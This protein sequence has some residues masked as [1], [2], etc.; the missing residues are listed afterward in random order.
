[1][2][3]VEVDTAAMSERD[4]TRWLLT[5]GVIGPVLFVV[6]FLI[7]G[8][9][10]PGYDP[11]RHFVSTL[12]LGDQ[13]WQQIANFVI[14]GI[15]IIAGAAGLRRTMRDG[16]G[17]RWGPILIGAAGLGVLLAGV[18][19]T[20]PAMGYP[21]G[22]PPGLPTTSSWHGTIHDMV[23]LVVF[24]GL[25]I[26]A[27]VMARR[28]RGERGRWALYSVLTG[29]GMLVGFVLIFVFQDWL[30]LTQ[31]IS[32]V[33]GFGWVAQLCLRF[34]RELSTGRA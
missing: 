34:R 11:M 5:G 18:F 28:F 21:P 3:R 17:S 26:A 23:S 7:E 25:P 16:P 4:K 13:G 8:W 12:S 29:I 27:F 2:R 32:I 15:L 9:T 20:D 22:S 6:V 31:R 19:V 33:L 1:M 30:G 10:R 24:S 14:T